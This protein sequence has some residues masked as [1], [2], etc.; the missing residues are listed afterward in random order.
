MDRFQIFDKVRLIIEPEDKG[1]ITAIVTR[2]GII[3]YL[4]SFGLDGERE[5]Y[6]REIEKI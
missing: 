2:P 1:I 5:V 6:E 4:V 3:T